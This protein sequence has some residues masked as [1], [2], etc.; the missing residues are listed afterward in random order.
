MR[1]FILLVTL[2]AIA[3]A[4]AADMPNTKRPRGVLNCTP[5]DGVYLCRAD[6]HLSCD[7]GKVIPFPVPGKAID[8][9]DYFIPDVGD[10]IPGTADCVTQEVK[11]TGYIDLLDANRRHL[12]IHYGC[13][14]T[15]TDD[16]FAYGYCSVQSYDVMRRRES[17]PRM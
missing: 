2:L 17:S 9:T 1:I 8:N 13:E 5:A 14:A 3:P 11:G 10:L 4:L 15:Y 12:K 6:F 16:A 7:K